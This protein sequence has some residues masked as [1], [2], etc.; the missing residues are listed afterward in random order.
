MVHF[1]SLANG[2]LVTLQSVAY[3]AALRNAVS[4]PL[5]VAWTAPKPAAKSSRG[6]FG[7]KPPD[8]SRIMLMVGSA[9]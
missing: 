4:S 1:G 3:T 6:K 2:L 8:P 9:F 5:P 7:M